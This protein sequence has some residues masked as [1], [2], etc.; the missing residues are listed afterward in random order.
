MKVDNLVPMIDFPR[1]TKEMSISEGIKILSSRIGLSITQVQK[2]ARDRC[3]LR[4]VLEER[5]HTNTFKVKCFLKSDIIFSDILHTGYDELRFLGIGRRYLINKIL[6]SI[7]AGV[8]DAL[9]PSG[10]SGDFPPRSWL[11]PDTAEKIKGVQLI[12]LNIVK[13]ENVKQL[14]SIKVRLRRVATPILL[15]LTEQISGIRKE[16]RKASKINLFSGLKRFSKILKDYKKKF[17]SKTREYDIGN[18]KKVLKKQKK[19][20]AI[21]IKANWKYSGTRDLFKA[22]KRSES[23][24]GYSLLARS[25]TALRKLVD[26]K[27]PNWY[28]RPTDIDWSEGIR[29]EK[30]KPHQLHR[31]TLFRKYGLGDI[32]GITLPLSVENWSSVRTSWTTQEV[33]DLFEEDSKDSKK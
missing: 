1:I 22:V 26:P 20:K 14:Q 9:D 18:R 7:L 15:A 17:Y 21:L 6:R 19:R 5:R 24:R 4:E 27:V 10:R 28:R 16:V 23:M 11:T 32:P 3:P 8:C 2:L 13:K 12:G 31:R 33:R 25:L 29:S 30:R